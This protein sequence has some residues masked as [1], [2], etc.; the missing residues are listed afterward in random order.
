MSKWQREDN[1]TTLFLSFFFWIFSEFSLLSSSS[2]VTCT[3]APTSP[4]IFPPHFF[5]AILFIHSEFYSN[6]QLGPVR[7][8]PVSRRQ[9]AFAHAARTPRRWNLLRKLFLLKWN[10]TLLILLKW[11]VTL[12]FLLKWNITLLILLKWNITLWGTASL[13]LLFLS[14]HN[15][16]MRIYVMYAKN[17]LPSLLIINK[18]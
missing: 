5:W 4:F 3:H 7:S 16:C 10:I 2:I 15:V 13:S 1:K 14:R 9:L 11:N 17:S 8:S 12:L 6:F 18:P